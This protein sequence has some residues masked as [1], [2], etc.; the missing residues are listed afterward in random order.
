MIAECPPVETVVMSQIGQDS[1]IRL[2]VI[3]ARL[4]EAAWRIIVMA[5][6]FKRMA[7]KWKDETTFM[8]D[9]DGIISNRYYQAIIAQPGNLP[10]ILRDLQE[11]G[12]EWFEA[13]R[14][15]TNEDPIDPAIYGDYDLMREAWLNWG[16]SKGYL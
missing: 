14:L 12:G 3:R 4:N 10:L 7:Q 5:Q 8:S 13:L 11:N 2:Q 9:P 1:H 16:R 6:D 15:M